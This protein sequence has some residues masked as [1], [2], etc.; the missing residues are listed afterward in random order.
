VATQLINYAVPLF[1]GLFLAIV[2]SAE[3]GRRIGKWRRQG[4]AEPWPGTAAVDAAIFALF[5]LLLAFAFSSAAARFDHRRDMI[6]AEANDI[7][8][9]YLRI[10]L[11]PA[12]AQPAL[13]DA[14]RRY[15]D[16]RVN[17]YRRGIDFEDF[18]AGLEAS[19]EIQ[20]E[21]WSLAVAAGRM[22]EA[23]PS[24]NMLLLPALNQMIDITT[25]RAMATVSHPPAIIY[26]LLFAL[27]LI[28]AL[29]AG[30][31]MAAARS[32]SSFHM[33]G[34]AA[35]LTITLYVIVDLEFPRLGFIQVGEFD[36]LLLRSV[37]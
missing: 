28:C 34:F 17:A 6:V 36:R 35:I 27:A 7:S 26:V 25:T 16:S 11:A 22:P 31:G 12:V 3:I 24:L 14:F 32:R 13:R 15:V 20:Q 30:H 18:K 10:D 37:D 5:G 8:T 29:I 9:A 23:H 1:T 19:E 21:I 2:L 33:V 4:L